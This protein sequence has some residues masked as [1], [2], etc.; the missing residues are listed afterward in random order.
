[1]RLFSPFV[2]AAEKP[3]I[4]VVEDEAATQFILAHFLEEHGFTVLSAS[5]AAEA[6]ILLETGTSIAAVFTDVR[7]PDMNGH[8]LAQ[9]IRRNRP[10]LPIVLGSGSGLAPALA[11][12]ESYAFF[13]KPYDFPA[14][15]QHIRGLVSRAA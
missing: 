1:M 4:L 7:L 12:G 6:M 10:D 15:A 11:T 8:A 2:P 5:C 14:I 3:T 13:M 9:A